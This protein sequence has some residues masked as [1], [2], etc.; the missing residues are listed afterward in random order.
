M[1]TINKNIKS[2]LHNI[3]LM[4][5]LIV[6]IYLIIL[7]IITIFSSSNGGY[8][9][10]NLIKPMSCDTVVEM[11]IK[12]DQLS[13]L[14]ENTVESGWINKLLNYKVEIFKPSIVTDLTLNNY[15]VKTLSDEILTLKEWWP[16][17]G[18]KLNVIIKTESCVTTPSLETV[19]LLEQLNNKRQLNLDNE[20][21]K[22]LYTNSIFNKGVTPKASIINSNTDVGRALSW[23]NITSQQ[24]K[25]EGQQIRLDLLQEQYWK[26]YLANKV[27][28][29]IANH[30][31]QNMLPTELDIPQTARTFEFTI[32]EFKRTTQNLPNL[33]INNLT[34]CIDNWVFDNQA[35]ISSYYTNGNLNTLHKNT[36]INSYLGNSV[37]CPSSFPRS[38]RIDSN[39][40]NLSEHF[41][42]IAEPSNN[43]TINTD[44]PLPA[45][46]TESISESKYSKDSLSQYSIRTSYLIDNSKIIKELKNKY[47]LDLLNPELSSHNSILTQT[48]KNSNELIEGIHNNIINN[49]A[50]P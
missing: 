28:G 23:T 22:A 30:K 48:S 8:G 26:K 50:K 29:V 24:I 21:I 3:I 41:K 16:S 32:N 40:D 17:T 49:S 1:N 18:I 34:T 42:G 2:T 14:T 20:S 31:I 5:F 10:L 7:I 19:E 13:Y 27:A 44:K 47:G 36:N 39:Y 12:S 4:V 38:V 46:P 9:I 35:R 43:I 37:A 15:L 45:L 6:T 25:L 11:T 33:D